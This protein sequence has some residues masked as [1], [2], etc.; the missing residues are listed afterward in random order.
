MVGQLKRFGRLVPKAL[1]VYGANISEATIELPWASVLALVLEF[2]TRN[3]QE[4][5]SFRF[6]PEGQAA[7][8]LKKFSEEVQA[9]RRIAANTDSVAFDDIADELRKRGFTKRELKGFQ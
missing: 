2:G 6:R 4:Q 7:E 3:Q 1:G 5:L 9:T 8:L